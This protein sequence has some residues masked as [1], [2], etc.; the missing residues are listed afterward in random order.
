MNK[1]GSPLVFL[2]GAMGTRLKS[3]GEEAST[4]ANLKAPDTVKKIHREYI[5]AGSQIIETNTFSATSVNYS[6]YKKLNR[7]GIRLAKE[8]VGEAS[9]SRK[10]KIAGSVGPTGKMIKPVGKL[11][12][13][14][15]VEIFKSQ[16]EIMAKEEVDL[17]IIETMD[18][19]LEMKAAL[20]AAGEVAPGIPVFSTMTFSEGDRTSTGTPP[21]VAARVMDSLGADVLGV[22]CSFG[23]EKLREPVKRMRRVTKKPIIV[24]ANAGLPEYKDNRTVYSMDP[25]SYAE[26]V[27]KLIKEGATYVGGC[28]GT[29][30]EFIKKMVQD[31]GKL[32]S[33]FWEPAP[34]KIPVVIASRTSW[35]E[36]NDFPVVIGERINL[37]AH[38]ELKKSDEKIVKEGLKQ[39]KAGA[40][41][42]DINLANQE[43]R[44]PQ[45]ADKLSRRVGLPL[46]LDCQNPEVLKKTVRRCGG[47]PLLNSISGEEKKLENLLPVVKK[48]GIPFVGLCMDEEGVPNKV[49]KKVN[50]ARKIVKKTTQ[51]GIAE[52]N[53]IIDP[54]AFALSSKPGSARNTIKALTE[55]DRPTLLGISNI[56]SGLPQQ[57][58]LNQVFTAITVYRGISGIIVN[59]MDKDLMYNMYASAAISGRKSSVNIK[60]YIEYFSPKGDTF[61]FEDKLSQ[62]ILEGNSPKSSEIVE[63]RLDGNTGLK[64]INQSVIPALKKVGEKYNK[65]QIFLPQL[66]ESARAAQKTMDIISD[67]IKEEGGSLNKKGKIL[68]ATVE[69]DIHDI[70]KNLVT[71]ILKNHSFKVKDMGV[72][73]SAG[74]IVEE[75]RKWGADIIALSSLMTTT[76]GCMEKVV[77]KLKTRNMDIPVIIGGAAVRKNYA[78][79]IGA[80]YGKDALKA[81][82]I[83]GSLLEK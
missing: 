57:A 36:F 53:I 44:L 50:I 41:A 82:D 37:T 1:S 27:K 22:N 25:E 71:L 26:N 28:C 48:Y 2:D 45:I 11:E 33:E 38:P 77:K 35:A 7:R 58:L 47:V 55:I 70:G 56:S 16:L 42:L 3:L 14:E 80:Y 78:Q 43:E 66:I 74:K 40:D 62:A 72:D 5:K 75:A 6:N 83:A 81:V 20:L 63:K 64:I 9:A 17:I 79:K 10:V 24:Q 49:E 32:S 12:F 15:G 65:K 69:G 34:E 39:K 29:D 46:V 18:D 68:I 67:R 52:E 76:M 4:L 51:A 31:F 54:V 13:E 30:P 59:P 21:E 19:I 60:K 8:A 61:E 73:N 23:P